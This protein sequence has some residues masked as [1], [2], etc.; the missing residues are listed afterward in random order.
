MKHRPV[1]QRQRRV[2]RISPDAPLGKFVDPDEGPPKVT[3]PQERY[4][5]GWRQ[6]SFDLA[7]GLEV[8]EETDTVPGDFMDELFNRPA[9]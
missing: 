2:W 4:E 5:P 6:S 1:P 3:E 7:Y 9:K 8:R